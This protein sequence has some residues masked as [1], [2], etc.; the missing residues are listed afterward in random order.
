[1]RPGS[2][3]GPPL[4][5]GRVPRPPHQGGRAAALFGIAFLLLGGAALLFAPTVMEL[6]ER[7]TLGLQI[8]GGLLLA[9][10]ALGAVLVVPALLHG[11]RNQPV[12]EICWAPLPARTR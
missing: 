3:A 10:G 12:A 9:P 11:W 6:N 8:L 2:E 4:P 7:L 5:A 1:M